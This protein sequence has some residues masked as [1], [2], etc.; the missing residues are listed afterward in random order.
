MRWPMPTARCQTSRM[1]ASCI[2]RHAFK[3]FRGG[4]PT[5]MYLCKRSTT[6]RLNDLLSD[7]MTYFLNERMI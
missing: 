5:A 3:K 4:I 2:V 6:K 1:R 7:K